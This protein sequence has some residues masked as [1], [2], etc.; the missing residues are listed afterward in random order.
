[1]STGCEKAGLE[2]ARAMV[3]ASACKEACQRESEEWY[4]TPLAS[5]LRRQDSFKVFPKP[6]LYSALSFNCIFIKQDAKW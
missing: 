3:A 4:I 6:L 1:M 2:A 5:C